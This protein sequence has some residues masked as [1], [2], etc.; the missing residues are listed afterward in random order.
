MRMVALLG[1]MRDGIAN[2]AIGGPLR[3]IAAGKLAQR[4]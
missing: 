4:G 2:E 3:A 1:E